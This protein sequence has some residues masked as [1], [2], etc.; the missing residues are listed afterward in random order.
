MALIGTA[1]GENNFGRFCEAVA[2][3]ENIAKGE[4]D[5]GC[6]A[7]GR[8][9]RGPGGR[10]RGGLIRWLRDLSIDAR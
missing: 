9:G 10:A 5:L 4:T 8:P 7:T 2:F 6:R 3:G 1:M